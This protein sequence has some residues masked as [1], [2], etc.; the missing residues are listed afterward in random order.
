MRSYLNTHTPFKIIHENTEI[1]GL[2]YTKMRHISDYK[3][4]K[5][6]AIFECLSSINKRNTYI[7][8]VL[9]Y[10]EYYAGVALC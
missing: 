1:P 8:A 3:R 10:A 7:A 5:M 2:L 9:N 6:N 4:K